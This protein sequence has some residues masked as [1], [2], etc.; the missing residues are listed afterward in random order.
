MSGRVERNVGDMVPILSAATHQ[1][2]AR[3]L[4]WTSELLK[5]AGPMLTARIRPLQVEEFTV[6]G[7]DIQQVRDLARSRV[8]EGWELTDAP[9]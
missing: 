2:R 6:Q 1:T 4:A 9:I 8:P 3:R 5:Y 7:D